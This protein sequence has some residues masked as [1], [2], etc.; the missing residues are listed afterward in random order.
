M[1]AAQRQ[2]TVAGAPL[3]VSFAPLVVCIRLADR[4]AVNALCGSIIPEACVFGRTR[5]M[6]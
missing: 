6:R 4:A 3:D 5:G 2:I 1:A